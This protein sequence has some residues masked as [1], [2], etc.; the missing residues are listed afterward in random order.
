MP[1][2]SSSREVEIREVLVNAVE[3]QLAAMK[4]AVG[5]WREW[6]ERTMEFVKTASTQMRDIRSEDKDAGEVLLEIT[7]M[8]RESVR[9]MT[10]LPRSAAERF[11]A[12]LDAVEKRNRAAARKAASAT[13]ASSAGAKKA[14][15]RRSSKATRRARVKI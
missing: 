14:T 2:K 9:S 11:I 8:A 7:D 4:A 12:E 6:M 10:D 5:F 13:S 3:V 15:R 1:P